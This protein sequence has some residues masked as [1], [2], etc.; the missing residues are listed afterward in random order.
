[1]QRVILF[2]CIAF[3]AAPAGADPVQVS[4]VN[5]RELVQVPQG[6]AYSV[7][8]IGHSYG[9]SV[10]PVASL[11]LNLDRFNRSGARA[12]F[13]LG[14][15]MQILSPVHRSAF[16]RM[17]DALQIP[18][19]IAPGNHDLREPGVFEREY[20]RTSY[21]LRIGSDLYAIFDLNLNW[22]ALPQDRL[23]EFLR[24][25]AEA[26][27]DPSIRNVVILTHHL[28]WAIDEP[29]LEIVRSRVNRPADYRSG[30][31]AQHLQPA[32]ESLAQHKPVYW[33]SGDRTHFPPLYWKV[34]EQNITYIAT[35]LHGR[36]NDL[37]V[38]LESSATGAIR[39][40]LESLAG[41]ELDPIE[42]YGPDYWTDYYDGVLGAASI[43]KPLPMYWVRGW[44]FVS[45]RR[46][47]AG[48]AFGAVLLIVA[49]G[50]ARVFRR[51]T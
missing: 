12:L 1:M 21:Q 49:S 48:A 50:V 35:G 43:R 15:T 18:V 13:L 22:E 9:P 36:E 28:V 23:D 8:L 3:L 19:Y 24:I 26:E 42:Q 41:R 33:I 37:A 46:F 4:P 7:W 45:N 32:L 20:G 10:Y 51:K 14:D 40:E 29:R 34:P 30:V 25:L 5:G 2:L 16:A 31:F 11:L 39:F 27:R 38:R 44:M 6:E 17:T 47:I